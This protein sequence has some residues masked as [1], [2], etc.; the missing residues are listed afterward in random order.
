MVNLECGEIYQ[1]FKSGCLKY[2][3]EG[4]NY[5]TST[6]NLPWVCVQTYTSEN[7]IGHEYHKSFD[8]MCKDVFPFKINDAL[9]DAKGLIKGC[10]DNKN[11]FIRLYWRLG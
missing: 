4:I 8:S 2:N 11:N 7:D 9:A 10:L 1:W 5:G 6:L 3:T